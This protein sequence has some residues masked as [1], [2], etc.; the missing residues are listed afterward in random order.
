MATRKKTD[1]AAAEAWLSEPVTVR[2]FRDNGSYKE[3]KVVTV[4]GETVRVPRGENLAADRLTRRRIECGEG[5]LA[6]RGNVR[7]GV[8]KGTVPRFTAAENVCADR[9]AG[10][11]QHRQ[12]NRARR[13]ERRGDAAGEVSAAAPVLKAVVLTVGGVVRVRGACKTVGIVAAAGVFVGDDDGERR[14]GG[15]SLPDAAEN[16]IVVWLAAGGVHRRRGAAAGQLAAQEF[17][18]DR[19]TRREPVEH[20]T[21]GGAV[22]LAEQGEC[23]GLTECVFHSRTPSRRCRISSGIIVVKRNEP[24][25]STSTA[26]TAA[27]CP[28]LSWRR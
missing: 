26:V 18:I 6:Q 24:G 16:L 14:P 2:L 7:G 27:P 8:G 12:H 1:R 21:D 3:D 13:D 17:L 28:F 4:N 15:A 19:Q 5:G 11:A 10:G 23:H 9:D 20:S 22:A 25:S